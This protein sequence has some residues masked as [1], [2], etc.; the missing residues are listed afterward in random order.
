MR[1]K[2]I[3]KK[4][5]RC[6]DTVRINAW[7]IISTAVENAVMNGLTRAYKHS[8]ND[9]PN[10]ERERILEYVTRDVMEHLSQVLIFDDK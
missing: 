3:G 7:S 4:R 8:E 2:P 5:V 1:S 6:H 10:D 9:L